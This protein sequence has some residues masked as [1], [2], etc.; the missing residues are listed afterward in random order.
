MIANLSIVKPTAH[1][2]KIGM[3]GIAND[4][5]DGDYP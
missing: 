2:L 5:T 4:T 3:M 1:G